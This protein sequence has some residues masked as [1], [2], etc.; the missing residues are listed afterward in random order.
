MKAPNIEERV[1]VCRDH[2]DFSIRWK[3]ERTGIVEMRRHY[4][5]YFKGFDHFKE[6]RVK[7]VSSVSFDEIYDLLDEV[8]LNYAPSMAEEGNLLVVV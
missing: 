7:L 1:K 4:S 5:N 3:G 6:Y 8:L 2:L